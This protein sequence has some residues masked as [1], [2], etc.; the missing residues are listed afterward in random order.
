MV[1]RFAFVV[2]LIWILVSAFP[3]VA[4]A[5]A[6]LF[7]VRGYVFDDLDKDA[8]L[9]AADQPIG[10]VVVRL[11]QDNAP[12]GVWDSTDAWLISVRSD[13]MGL[14]VFEELIAGHYLIVQE[15]PVGY[16]CTS[17]DVIGLDLGGPAVLSAEELSFANVY[18]E[19][20]PSAG[21]QLFIPAV[22][23]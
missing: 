12:L 1:R 19:L 18:A 15:T 7:D 3:G 10:D 16:D 22:I 9:T 11:Y 23:G 20:Y 6:D 4:A 8:A 13:D 17:G 2:A 21:H 5:D 14:Y